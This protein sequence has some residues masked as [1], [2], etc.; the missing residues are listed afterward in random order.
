MNV[1]TRKRYWFVYI[2]LAAVFT[3]GIGLIVMPLIWLIDKSMAKAAYSRQE[4]G[5]PPCW[6]DGISMWEFELAS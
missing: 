2:P 1:K 5:L 6:Y 4:A 3:M